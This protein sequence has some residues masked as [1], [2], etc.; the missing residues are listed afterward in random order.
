MEVPCSYREADIEAVSFRHIATV[1]QLQLEYTHTHTHTH[2]H[3]Q[4]IFSRVLIS[5]ISVNESKI[6]CAHG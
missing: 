2:T 3:T 4:G 1:E 5:A 6:A